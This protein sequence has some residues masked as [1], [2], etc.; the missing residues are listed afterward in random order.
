MDKQ[1]LETFLRGYADI[2]KKDV[3]IL[4]DFPLSFR[5][6]MPLGCAVVST[7]DGR[8][9]CGIHVE[10]DNQCSSMPISG[11]DLTYARLIVDLLNRW[12]E[13]QKE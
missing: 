13:L 4:N 12:A 9:V 1:K 7:S 6:P 3:D 8:D 5:A 10:G 11:V 2:L